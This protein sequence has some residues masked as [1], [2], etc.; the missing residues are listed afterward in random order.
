[1]SQCETGVQV[2]KYRPVLVGL[3]PLIKS[4]VRGVDRGLPSL[5]DQGIR[6]VSEMGCVLWKC[7]VRT[8]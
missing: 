3:R 2:K 8:V 5:L 6:V 4:E 1:M 7:F